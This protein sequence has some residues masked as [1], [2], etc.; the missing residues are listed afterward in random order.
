MNYNISI[1]ILLLSCQS[2]K[3]SDN[4][5]IQGNW[6]LVQKTKLNELNYGKI[7]FS[8]KL[9]TLS[10]RADTLYS[11]NYKI[12]KND[13]SIFRYLNKDTIHN[14]IE[15]ITKDSLILSTLIEKKIKQV[16]FRCK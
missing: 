6:C 8:D 5:D 9:I 10:S 14:K 2:T 3:F 16:Y 4:K 13:L 7:S 12:I 15:K 11:Y 1:F